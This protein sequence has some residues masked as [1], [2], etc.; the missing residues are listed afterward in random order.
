MFIKKL[1][2]N[3]EDYIWP[4]KLFYAIKKMIIRRKN[5]VFW[6]YCYIKQYIINYD[7][8]QGM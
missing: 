3:Y 2:E 7:K 8:F 5:D 1:V 4:S 6:L